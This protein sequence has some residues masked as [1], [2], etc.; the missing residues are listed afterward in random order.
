MRDSSNKGI[1]FENEVAGK[2][3][4]MGFTH[5]KITKRSRD[6]GADILAFKNGLEYVIQCKKY[7]GSVG[8]NGVKDVST[9]ME[10]YQADKGILVCDTTFTKPAYKAVEKIDKPIELVGLKEIRA[11]KFKK[12]KPIKYTRHPYQN[13]I[14]PKIVKHRKN[15]NP[16]A[17]L[18][19]ATGLGKTLIAAWDLKNQIKKGEKALF[20]VHRKDILVDNEEKFHAIINEE[21]KKY[22]FGVYFSGK[23]FKKEDIVFSTFQTIVKHYKKIPK[24]YFDYII[25]DEAHHS[26]AK[27]YAEVLEYY[28]PKFILGITATPKRIT[29]ADNDFIED[30][31]GKPLVD[32]DLAEALTRGYLSPVKYSVFCD[33]IDYGKLNSVNKKLSI[34]QLNQT[35]FIPTKDEDI[36]RIIYGEINKTKRPRTIIFC[37]T[38]KYIRSVKKIGLYKDAEIY[39]STMSDFD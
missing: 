23:K 34:E 24:K 28:Q 11:W 12:V 25:I 18:V 4:G 37:P 1:I 15:G 26:P 7:A 10:V 17:L 14:L 33:N 39:H 19:M 5:V 22:E 27:T 16:S 35:Y 3:K 21:R 20:L 6:Y 29:K 31:F 13:K 8:Y 2:L 38:I 30:V 36:E 32:L 9:A